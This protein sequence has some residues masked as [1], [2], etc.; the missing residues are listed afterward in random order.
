M[1]IYFG[2]NTRIDDSQYV[3][4]CAKTYKIRIYPDFAY[5]ATG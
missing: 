3:P 5:S 4:G 2:K 1:S